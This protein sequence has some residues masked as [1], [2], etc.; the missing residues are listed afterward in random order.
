MEED[1]RG[2]KKEGL[3]FWLRSSYQLLRGSWQRGCVHRR[4]PPMRSPL[5]RF[6]TPSAPRRAVGFFE[7]GGSR[8]CLY[9]R[10]TRPTSD[11]S[12]LFGPVTLDQSFRPPAFQTLRLPNR[13]CSD[14][15][16]NLYEQLCVFFSV[17]EPALGWKMQQSLRREGRRLRFFLVLSTGVSFRLVGKKEGRPCGGRASCRAP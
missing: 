17:L 8:S 14:V 3:R 12:P 9:E 1:A 11:W 5:L 15:C 13:E 4:S 16:H 6:Q 10:V 2:Q 7:F